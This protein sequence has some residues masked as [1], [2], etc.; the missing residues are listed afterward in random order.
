MHCMLLSESNWQLFYKDYLFLNSLTFP[1]FLKSQGKINLIK[2]KFLKSN[3]KLTECAFL[4]TVLPPTPQ[5]FGQEI[6]RQSY[7]NF[8]AGQV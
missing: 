4:L 2:S 3:L 8:K 5:V 1:S 6:G 7:A